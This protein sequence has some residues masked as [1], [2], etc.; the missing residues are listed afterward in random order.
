MWRLLDNAKVGH[1]MSKTGQS[2]TVMQ[3][4]MYTRPGIR[5]GATACMK[6]QSLRLHFMSKR[7]G[8]QADHAQQI[9]S[10]SP[11]APDACCHCFAVEFTVGIIV[12]L[13]VRVCV[14]VRVCLCV[15]VCLFVCLCVSICV[16]LCVCEH[17]CHYFYQP[18][19]SSATVNES[20]PYCRCNVTSTS[21]LL[22]M[23]A[24]QLD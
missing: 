15:C 22:C 18:C 13:S 3:A 17:F 14:C 16:C 1:I 24:A 8:W 4:Y 2:L 23:E 10:E 7:S 12:C 11:A 6:S 21:S 20:V 9:Q 19:L 5:Y